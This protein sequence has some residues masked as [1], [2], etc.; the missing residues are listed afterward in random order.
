MSKVAIFLRKDGTLFN[1]FEEVRE[2]LDGKKV[3]KYCLD[4]YVFKIARYLKEEG[5]TERNAKDFVSEWLNRFG[6]H[7]S[8]CNL[9]IMNAYAKRGKMKRD[10]CVRINDEDIEKIKYAADYKRSR[11]LALFLLIYAKI[12]ADHDGNFRIR[13][14]MVGEWLGIDR[15][16][17]YTRHLKELISFGFVEKTDAD[18]D[19]AKNSTDG[20]FAHLRITYE[21]SNTGE[22]VIEHNEDFDKLYN[23]I[24]G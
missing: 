17:L 19:Y 5:Y 4:E 10:F 14:P 9:T 12:H 16:H 11:K 18:K 21:L 20:R 7:F 8:N 13:L 23:E 1:E 15:S 3:T 6:Y 2:Y 22:Y 24:F